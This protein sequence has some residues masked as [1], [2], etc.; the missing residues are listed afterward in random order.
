[1]EENKIEEHTEFQV[2]RLKV[3]TLEILL[4]KRTQNNLKP[5]WCI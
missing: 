4:E 1:M 3:I 5:S 2:G